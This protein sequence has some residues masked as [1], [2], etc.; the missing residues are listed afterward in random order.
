M[1]EIRLGL[2]ER[3]KEGE[4]VKVNCKE[5]KKDEKEE[6]MLRFRNEE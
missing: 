4:G 6:N 2:E 1:E 5:G 3:A